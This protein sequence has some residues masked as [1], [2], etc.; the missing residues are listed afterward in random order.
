M[1]RAIFIKITCPLKPLISRLPTPKLHR[2]SDSGLHK[3][4]HSRLVTRWPHTL[5]N[6]SAVS[7]SYVLADLTAIV[8]RR[9]VSIGSY[10]CGLAVLNTEVLETI[11]EVGW[12]ASTWA[13]WVGWVSLWHRDFSS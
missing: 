10:V 9:R 8:L 2:E 4:G 13:T 3:E 6:N 7:K 5:E 11:A 1:I 12:G